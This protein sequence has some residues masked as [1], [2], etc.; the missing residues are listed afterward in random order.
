VI[1]HGTVIARGT[2]DQLKRQIGGDQIEV[3]LEDPADAGRVI[4]LVACH[5]CGD[6]HLD[7]G[8][9]RTVVMPVITLD[10]MVPKVVRDLDQANIGVRATS[11]F[12][13]RPWTTSSSP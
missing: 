5:T 11:A 12:G 4:E 2:A 7:G 1:D 10:G 3:I 6:S 13:G 9:G 8:D